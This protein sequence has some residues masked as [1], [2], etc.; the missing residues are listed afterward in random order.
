MIKKNTKIVFEDGHE[1]DELAGGLP[2]SKGEI[3]RIHYGD[4]V[5]EYQV[6]E[7]AVDIFP[8]G[9]DQTVNIIYKLGQNS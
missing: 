4:N 8:G 7:K 2:L 5:E 6:I 1:M 3:I 9:D